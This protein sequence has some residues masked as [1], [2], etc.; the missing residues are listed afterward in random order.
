M[1]NG[2][3][4]SL[5][6]VIDYYNDPSSVIPD[7]INR[8]TLLNGKLNLTPQEKADLLAFLQTLTSASASRK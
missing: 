5:E 7:A 6:E 1:H 2:M 3:F 8:D 4:K